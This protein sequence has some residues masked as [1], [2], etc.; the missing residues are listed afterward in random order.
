M[1]IDA[2]TWLEN[3]A[4]RAARRIDV[5]PEE[6]WVPQPK[7]ERPSWWLSAVAVATLLLAIAV[8]VRMTTAPSQV[9]SGGLA[10]F[11]RTPADAEAWRQVREGVPA[12]VPML[13]PRLL[14][15]R[16]VTSDDRCGLPTVIGYR[17]E[18]WGLDV[19]GSVRWDVTYRQDPGNTGCPVVGI[20]MRVLLENGVPVMGNLRDI[21]PE[22]TL[23]RTVTVRGLPADVRLVASDG[24]LNVVWQEGLFVYRVRS[25]GL[26]TDELVR[27]AQS[28]EEVER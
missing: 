16:V 4:A 9:G 1:S 18:S 28:L 27:V 22:E 8:S 25:Y 13:R 12:W 14:P 5:P 21:R 24:E 10:P 2:E 6:R 19:S 15:P 23:V 17:A 7:A 11:A 26:T 20:E 3:A